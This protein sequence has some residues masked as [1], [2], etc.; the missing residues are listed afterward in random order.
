MMSLLFRDLSDAIH[1]GERLL[2]IRKSKGPREMMFV[3]RFPLRNLLQDFFAALRPSSEVRRR[4]REHRF[5][6]QALLS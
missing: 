4:G 6:W 3:D 1:K 2:E 5:G